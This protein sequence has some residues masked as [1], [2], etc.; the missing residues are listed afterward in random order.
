MDLVASCKVIRF[1]SVFVVVELF[2]FIFFGAN[3]EHCLEL[4]NFHMLWQ[5]DSL[6]KQ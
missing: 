1:N 4:F 5:L 3:C 6:L 2:V